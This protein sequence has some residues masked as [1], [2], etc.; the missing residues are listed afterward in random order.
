M[1]SG[2]R[3]RITVVVLGDL[4]RSP[5][6]LYHARS[7]GD[8]DTDVDLVGYVTHALPRAVAEHPRVHVHR[9]WAPSTGAGARLPRLAFL[10]Y[11][12]WRALRQT[13]E[14]SWVLLVRVPR[15]SV[16][17]VQNPPAIP[18]L[19]VALVVCRLRAARLVIDW[20][21][22]GHAMLGLTLGV[23]HPVVRAAT[24]Y[25]RTFGRAADAHLCV[26][27]AMRAALAERWGI[28]N[29]VV[30]YDR[31]ADVFVPTPADT[32]QALF[33]RLGADL[34]PRLA[35]DGP[36]RPALVV[37]PSSWTVD[38][39]IDLLLA[40]L[41]DLDRRLLLSMGV[42]R[43]PAPRIVVALTGDGP[44]RARYLPRIGALALSAVAIR[45]LWLDAADYP[46]VVGAADLGV[47]VHRSAS[48][49]DLPM[50]VADMFGAGVPVCALDYAPCLREQIDDGTTGVLFTSADEL[51]THLERLLGEYPARTT[52]LDQLRAAVVARESIRWADAWKEN[53][54]PVL[55]PE[56]GR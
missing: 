29:A 53:A 49:F 45:T 35:S 36:D 50:K 32:R 40:A 56:H 38:E 10:V 18:T 1:S 46:G 22:L 21:N 26:S 17:L 31:P 27:R 25:E 42:A 7:L 23:A 33:R 44:L 51:A 43:A 2:A 52:A 5:R 11:A 54:R 37:S 39:D 19:L 6:M 3:T 24:V 34:D 41:V 16:V 15:P 12:L 30:L 14:L 8:T 20:H 48:G 9:L 47:S 28:P 4:G 13:L 55:V